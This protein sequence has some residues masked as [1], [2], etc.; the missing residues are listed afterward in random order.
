REAM[1]QFH[2]RVADAEGRVFSHVEP[3]NSQEEAR[4]KLVDR[5]LY[6]YSVESRG[7]RLR[8][9]P[10]EE[11]TP[12]WRFG[13]PHSQSA[14]Q[15]ADQSRFANLEIFGSSLQP[16]HIAQTPS[17]HHPD[18]GPGPGGQVAFRGCR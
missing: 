7:G 13:I 2:C 4:Q 8:A 17:G 3:A 16:S 18:P 11:W 14:I 9:G 6:V 10:P 5:G 12:D 1:G 15:H